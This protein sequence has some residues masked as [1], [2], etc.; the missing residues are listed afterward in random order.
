MNVIATVERRGN[1]G[2]GR[3]P[4]VAS[5]GANSSYILAVRTMGQQE[6]HSLNLIGLALPVAAV[7]MG[8]AFCVALGLATLTLAALGPGEQGTIAALKVTARFSFLLFWLAYAAGAMTTL[9]GP[10]FGPLKRRGREF[11]LAFASAHLVHLGLVAWL[12]YIGAAPSRGVFLFFGVAVFWTYL[13]ALFSIP[14]LQKALGSKGWWV[15]RVVGLNYIAL[16]F[17]KDFLGISPQFGN[18]KYLVGY[19]PFAALSVVGPLL[20]FAAFLQRTAWLQKISS[21]QA[22]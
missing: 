21:R 22:G 8:S 15:V 6:R 16:A 20:C 7:W 18:F 12:T 13:L 2:S 9:F 11:G 10:A 5:L 19:L 3:E 4:D 14:H 1:V 17:A